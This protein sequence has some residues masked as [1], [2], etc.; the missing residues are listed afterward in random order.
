MKVS[1]VIPAYNEEAYI[2]DCLN[3]ILREIKD[4][5]HQAEIIV[6]N[7]AS[8]DK[9][10][11]I[12]KNFPEVMLVHE[13]RK[14]LSQARQSGFLASSGDIIA[15][16]DADTRL[17]EGWIKK[18]VREFEADS[19]LVALSGPFVYYDMPLSANILVRLFYY[20]SFVL[21][22]GSMLQGGNFVLHAPTLK[23]IGG[24][25]PEYVFY[26]EDADIARR[27]HEV[28]RVKFTM[29]LPIYSSGRRLAKEGVLVMG[30]RYAVNHVWTIFFKKPFTHT[31]KDLSSE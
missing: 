30:F 21:K 18:V 15:N 19:K 7:N 4:G 6:V 26:G 12:V 9:T 3:S 25:N 23:N 27:M 10:P 20:I 11:E 2:E 5:N 24:F 22:A 16:V 31:V 14:G 13:A 8:T 1:F 17:T 28:G 29:K